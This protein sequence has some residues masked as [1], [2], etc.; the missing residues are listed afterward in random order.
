MAG[1]DDVRAR[2]EVFA[3]GVLLVLFTVV[4]SL[5]AFS[6]PPSDEAIYLVLRDEAVL[7]DLDFLDW[8]LT[9]PAVLVLAAP[10]LLAW[11]CR[12]VI[13]GT[14]VA[15]GLGVG[16]ALLLQELVARPRPFDSPATG[17]D[18]YPVTVLV[19]LAVL[20]TVWPLWMRV[21]RLPRGWSVLTVG[22]LVA[23][24]WRYLLPV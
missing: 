1:Y 9:L 12:V 22:V 6:S 18:S 5:A 10:L 23:I 4:T 2:R 24:A 17:T 15:V 19:V 16:L 11:Q 13:G 14:A 20:L 3:L 7:S 21:V 8:F